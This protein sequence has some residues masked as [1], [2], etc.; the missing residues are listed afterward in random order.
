MTQDNQNKVRPLPVVLMVLI[1]A[2][3]ALGGWWLKNQPPSPVIN[4]AGMNVPPPLN[5]V[6]NKKQIELTL[7][8][9]NDNAMLEKHSVEDSHGTS[10]HFADLARNAFSLL[11]EKAPAN[12]PAG[13]K[14][15]DVKTNN[16]GTDVLNFNSKFSDSNFWHGS[17]LSLMGTYSIVNTITALPADDFKAQRVQ[18][19]V[20]GKPITV[21]GELDVHDPLEPDMQWVQKN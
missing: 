12:F 1:L 19:L 8:I 21:L 4:A 20:E 11:L 13:T 3:V 5:T 9:P 18:F 16:N 2:A 17:A 10:A 15:L 7:F 14:L 6:P